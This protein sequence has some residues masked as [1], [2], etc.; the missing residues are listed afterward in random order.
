MQR[1][2]AKAKDEL[3]RLYSAKVFDTLVVDATTD[4]ELFEFVETTKTKGPRFNNYTSDTVE[5]FVSR[6]YELRENN[7]NNTSR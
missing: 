4:P 2:G 7:V 6:I 3:Y 1:T 5:H